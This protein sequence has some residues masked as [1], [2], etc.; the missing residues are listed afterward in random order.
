MVVVRDPLMQRRGTGRIGLCANVSSADQKRDQARQVQRLQG[1]VS[2]RGNQVAQ[3]LT[4]IASGL[5][6]N[7][8]KFLKLQADPTIGTIIVEHRYRS[9]RLGWPYISTLMV[10]QGRR[11]VA[12]HAPFKHPVRLANGPQRLSCIVI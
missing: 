11:T 1:S 7:H 6:E 4:E 2:A 9:T 8:P 5:D 12:S 10:A 3:E